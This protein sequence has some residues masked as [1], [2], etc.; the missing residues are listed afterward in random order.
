MA[1]INEADKLE[2]AI[3][4]KLKKQI[5]KRG[6]IFFKFVSP[7]NKGVPDR[8]A[9]LP[10]GRLYFIE[11]KRPKGG[12]YAPLQVWQQKR[13]KEFKQEV[14]CIKNTEEAE[15]FMEEIEWNSSHT[16]TSNTQ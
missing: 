8:I 12:R 3:E 14:R 13:L 11:L 9:I 4:N 6:G 2:R 16:T 15:K 10:D 7:G 5:E 1:E